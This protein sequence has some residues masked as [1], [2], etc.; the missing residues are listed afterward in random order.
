MGISPVRGVGG[1]VLASAACVA[2]VLFGCLCIGE[3][4]AYAKASKPVI[5]GLAARPAMVVSGGTSMVS[6]AVSGAKECTISSNKPVAGLPVTSSCE[7]GSV[8]RILMMPAN[9]G[10]KTAKYKLTLVATGADGKK[11]KAKSTV[12]VGLASQTPGVGRQVVAAYFYSCALLSTAG[13]QCWGLNEWGQ[14]GD[15]TNKGPE[16]CPSGEPETEEGDYC[17]R[18]PVDVNAIG[19]AIQVA[20]A[21]DST[22]AVLS[23]GHIDCWGNNA[24]GQ[25]GTGTFTGPEKCENDIDFSEYCSTTPVEVTGIST[26]TQIS[27][28]EGGGACALLSN[29][30][31]D[32]WGT[33]GPDE[34]ATATPVEVPGMSNAIQIAAG[35]GHTCALLATGHVDC[36]GGNQEGELGDGTHGAPEPKPVEVQGLSDAI[37]VAAD[38]GDTC[39]LLATAHVDCWG[40]NEGGELGDGTSE[41]PEHCGKVSCSVKPVEVEAIS[42]ANQIAA[43]DGHACAVLTTGHIE[44]WGENRIGELGNGA[45]GPERCETYIKN[46]TFPC[47]TKPVE[48]QRIS[49][50]I[51]ADPGERDAC[52]LLATGHIECWGENGYGQMGI[53]TG[54]PRLNN[55]PWIYLLPVE[56]Q[57]I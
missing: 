35:D 9:T 16:R 41:G 37:Q 45:A 25:L 54:S 55:S 17:S 5:S 12:E 44:C 39:A 43:G 40:D 8:S 18:I 1:R 3:A 2:L 6:A 46:G 48:V 14:L 28:N 51:Q 56:V 22:C 50:A 49:N 33:E 30:H 13:L 52:A 4:A 11:A 7:G 32:C 42:D 29:G 34:E 47:S 21:L 57:G 10:K 38:E 20:A 19:N 15:G 36:F 53:G 23:S 24:E 31:V 26:A 27:A